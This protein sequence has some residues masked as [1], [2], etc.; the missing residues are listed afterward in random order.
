MAKTELATTG[1][2]EGRLTARQIER[3]VNALPEKLQEYYH[4]ITGIAKDLTEAEILARYDLGQTV[5]EMMADDEIRQDHPDAVEELADLASVPRKLIYDCK[6]VAETWTRDEVQGLISQGEGSRRLLWSHLTALKTVESAKRRDKLAQKVMKEGWSVSDLL[7][8]I[9]AR[10]ET[11]KAKSKKSGRPLSRPKSLGAGLRQVAAFTS[12]F[13]RSSSEVW[14]ESVFQE[15]ESIE[16]K[17]VNDGLLDLFNETK[18][19]LESASGEIAKDLK[20]IQAIEV[21]LNKFAK[22]KANDDGSEAAAPARKSKKAKLKL[23]KKKKKRAAA[24]VEA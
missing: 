10:E 15:L 19:S 22:D 14:S 17:D 6:N 11:K 1:G 12:K 2:E 16:A 20:R 4:K 23:K 3:K 5:I 21:R 24:P 9:A 13:V 8:Q 7:A 18:D